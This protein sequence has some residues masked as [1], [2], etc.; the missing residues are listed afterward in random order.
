MRGKLI[1]NA[2]FVDVGDP[3]VGI[4]ALNG[5]DN[6]FC[7]CGNK[8]VIGLLLFLGNLLNA[9]FGTVEHIFQTA[10]SALD[11]YDTGF[12]SSCCNILLN[13]SIKN[14]CKLLALKDVHIHAVVAVVEY[15]SEGIVSGGNKIYLALKFVI[16][17]LT[18]RYN[19]VLIVLANVG[20]IRVVLIFDI[21]ASENAR[22][23]YD[24]NANR[25]KKNYCDSCGDY[26]LCL[27]EGSEESGGAALALSCGSVTSFGLVIEA[28]E[29]VCGVVHCTEGHRRKLF[30]PL[31]IGCGSACGLWAHFSL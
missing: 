23:S 19:V 2:V 24:G 1:G 17:K 16:E 11:E 12:K 15:V 26:Y 18:V 13:G 27:V 8:E 21:V 31:V 25:H 5:V 20:H 3:V 29:I 30:G 22:A 4:I 10:V 14:A 6:G 7:I 9:L 28:S